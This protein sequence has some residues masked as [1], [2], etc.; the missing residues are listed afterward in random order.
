MKKILVI[1]DE[2]AVRTSL[3][4]LL[5]AEGFEVVGAENGLIGVGLAHKARPDLIICDIMMPQMDGYEVLAALHQNPLTATTP[6]IFLTAKADKSD[7]RGGMQQG[8]DDYLTKPFSR[9]ELLE[10]IAA[11]LDKKARLNTQLQQKLEDLSHNLAKSLPQEFS[12]PLALIQN[13]SQT[14]RRTAIQD[15]QV[16][17]IGAKIEE[18]AK[19]LSRLIQRFLLFIEL[20][21]MALNPQELK[22]L[23]HNRTKSAKMIITELATQIA[24]QADR[25]ND[26]ELGLQDASIQ[27]SEVALKI[28]VQELIE[29][30]FRQ[31]PLK[32]PV[33]ITSLVKNKRFILYVSAIGQDI[34]IEYIAN[35]GAYDLFEKKLTEQGSASLGFLIVKQLAELHGGILGFEQVVGR[36]TIVR[37]ELPTG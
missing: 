20:Q 12:A 7:L 17:E 25:P 27:M 34:P 30:A 9:L 19:D 24:K 23:H 3:L 2:Q 10:A 13:L 16:D 26:L 22:A 28:S 36:K 37:I 32:T 8:A 1:E 5:E 4:D 29:Q 31:S 33:R 18:A 6:F 35:S 15:P 21:M 14:L 11:R